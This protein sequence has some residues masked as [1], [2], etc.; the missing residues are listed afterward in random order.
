[1]H[2]VWTEEKEIVFND[3]KPYKNEKLQIE[4]IAKRI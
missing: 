4:R 2:T 1:M 3:N